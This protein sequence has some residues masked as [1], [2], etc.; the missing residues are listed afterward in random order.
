MYHLVSYTCDCLCWMEICFWEVQ[1]CSVFPDPVEDGLPCWAC[2]RKSGYCY[3]LLNMTAGAH[4]DTL[5]FT[6]EV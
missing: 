5:I 2:K 4:A 1:E 6:W 3:M